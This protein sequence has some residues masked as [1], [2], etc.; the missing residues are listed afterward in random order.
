MKDKALTK[1]QPYM[2]VMQQG[3]WLPKE[4]FQNVFNSM[5]IYVKETVD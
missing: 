2:K 1:S 3:R 4:D 5:K